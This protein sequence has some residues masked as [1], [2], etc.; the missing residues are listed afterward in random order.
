MN[1]KS[2]QTATSSVEKDFYKLLNRS[3]FGIDCR[4]NVDNC[5]VEPFYDDFSEISYIKNF[6]TILN[7]DTFRNFFPL[8]IRQ[9]IRA[10]Y[11]SKNVGLHRE[12]STYEARKKYYEGG[13]AE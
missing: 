13:K 3:N 7:D 11:N 9:E 10:T 12:E 2:R 5:Y 6:T 8:L 1:P 4:I